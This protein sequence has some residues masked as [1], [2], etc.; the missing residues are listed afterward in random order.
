MIF[1]Y[2]VLLVVAY[3]VAASWA[4]SHGG[5]RRLWL[6]GSATLVLLAAAAVGLGRHYAVPSVARLLLYKMAFTGPVVVVPTVL[7]SLSKAPPTWAGRLPVAVLG[8]C[9][10]IIC[11]WV[12]VV[13]AL[14][15][16]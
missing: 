5:R 4:V 13:F 8:A 6:T 10:G 2:V 16:W 14:G 15:V 11:G 1:L 7:L 3:A 12:L 9:I